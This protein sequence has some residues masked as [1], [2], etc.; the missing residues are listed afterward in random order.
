MKKLLLLGIVIVGLIIL[1]YFSYLSIE[2]A[3][4]YEYILDETNHGDGVIEQTRFKLHPT[5]D[6]LIRYSFITGPY[7]GFR[8]LSGMKHKVHINQENIGVN[9]AFPENEYYGIDKLQLTPS[10]VYG[11]ARIAGYYRLSDG[12]KTKWLN[13]VSRTSY[14]DDMS[15]YIP[16]KD[17][18]YQ[19]PPPL[20]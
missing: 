15:E 19:L 10:P 13:V 2:Q 7:F 14:G 16:D 6:M 1:A 4:K 17:N 18:F 11:L 9:I 3:R 5:E 20:F 8:Q 12:E